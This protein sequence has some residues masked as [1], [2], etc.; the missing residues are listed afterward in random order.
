MILGGVYMYVSADSQFA[1]ESWWAYSW[2]GL[3]FC[4]I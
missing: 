4:I 3:Y 2:V 1:M